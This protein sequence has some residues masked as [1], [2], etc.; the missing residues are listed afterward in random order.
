MENLSSRIRERMAAL[1]E[2]YPEERINQRWLSKKTGVSTAAVS[3]WFDGSTSSLKSDTLMATA[4][5]LE[6]T[7]EWLNG[8]SSLRT[9]TTIKVR[10][11]RVWD[12]GDPLEDDEV[13][14][15]MLDIKLSAGSGR[16]QWEVSE[17][18]IYNRFRKS[19]CT[20]HGYNPEKLTTMQVDGESMSDVLPDG[21]SVTINTADI[22][23]KNGKIYAIDY[24]GQFMIKQLFVLPDGGVKI[25][26]KN[27]DKDTYPDIVIRPEHETALVV[28]GRAVSYSANI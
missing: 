26:S 17:S 5:A 11:I 24:L 2:K 8:T 23:I 4:K 13:E 7:P 21:A 3:K 20:S 10:P 1:Q 14:V 28:M 19:W 9:S 6:C 22:S 16:L 15:P 18:G 25:I 27:P 12:N